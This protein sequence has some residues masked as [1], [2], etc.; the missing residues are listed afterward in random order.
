MPIYRQ[1]AV[2]EV[3]Y[4][5][6]P[7]NTVTTVAVYGSDDGYT[8]PAT[9]FAIDETLMVA[10]SVVA[11]D[12]TD[13]SVSEVE[14]YLNGAYVGSAGLSFDVGAGVNYYQLTLGTLAEGDYTLEARFGRLR[15]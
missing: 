11:D 15:M 14:I 9:E 7:V 13:L 12:G 10:G 5:R 3:I 6:R 4:L 1:S 2:Q 8:V